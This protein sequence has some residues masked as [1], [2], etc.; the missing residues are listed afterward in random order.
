MRF[1]PDNSSTGRSLP[2]SLPVAEVL[3]NCDVNDVIYLSA[4]ESVHMADEWFNIANP[5]HFWI[6]RRFEVL[7]KLARDLGVRGRKTA[8]IGCGG[9]LVQQYLEQTYGLSVDGF[10]LNEA[11]LL[12]SVAVNHPRYCY[13]VLDRKPQFA[14]KYDLLV[15]FD[16]LEHIEQE[17]PFL[18]AVLFHLKPGGWLLINV[19]AL[20]SMYS[21]YD[22]VVGHQRR[23]TRKTLAAACSAV[24][25]ERVA[26]TYWGLPFLPLLLARKLWLATKQQEPQTVIRQGYKPPGRLGNRLL[27]AL[28]TLERIPQRLLGSS[29]MAI[30][31]KP[32]T[33]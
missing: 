1:L 21:H 9:G 4:P 6:K 19:P 22:R 17:K 23:Y 31:S 27:A 33:T 29:L 11:A 3:A 13:N 18:E 32:G 20:M 25:L 12:R 7:R 15:L 28:G 30:Y 8:E 26:E 14:A 16:V 10:D 2:G 24:G 5:G